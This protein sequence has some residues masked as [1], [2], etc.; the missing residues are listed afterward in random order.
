V[1]PLRLVAAAELAVLPWLF[2]FSTGIASPGTFV[3]HRVSREAIYASA[4][5]F[6]KPPLITAEFQDRSGSSIE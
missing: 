5:T 2:G 1:P 6:F 3:T 4:R